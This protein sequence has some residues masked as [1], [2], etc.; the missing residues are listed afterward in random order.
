MSQTNRGYSLI[1]S[2]LQLDIVSH[3]PDLLS[4]IQCHL[5]SS[6]LQFVLVALEVLEDLAHPNV[7]EDCS[8]LSAVHPK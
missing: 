4:E 8:M 7:Q 1:T 2:S 5:V 6:V 3:S